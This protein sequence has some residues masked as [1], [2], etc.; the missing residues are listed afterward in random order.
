MRLERIGGCGGRPIAPDCSFNCLT[1][2]SST[3]PG[4]H[5]SHLEGEEVPFESGFEYGLCTVS[6][7][8]VANCDG[9]YKAARLVKWDGL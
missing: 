1:I 3:W 2:G 8:E 4:D 6:I 7:D 5:H 9:A